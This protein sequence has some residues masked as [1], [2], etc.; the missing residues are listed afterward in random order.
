MWCVVLVL[1][2]SSHVLVIVVVDTD[3]Y[4]RLPSCAGAVQQQS[5]PEVEVGQVAPDAHGG[6]PICAGKSKAPRM[7]SKTL[8]QQF[9]TLLVQVA[10]AI[11]PYA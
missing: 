6:V 11:M 8:Q 10:H 1:E 3:A 5:A 9:T 7:M 2:W 4:A